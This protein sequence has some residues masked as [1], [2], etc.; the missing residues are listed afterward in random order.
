MNRRVVLDTNIIVSAMFASNSNPYRILDLA[1]SGAIEFYF[2]EPIFKEYKEVL[3]RPKFDFAVERIEVVLNSLR[4]VGN[5][6]MPI[7]SAF[8][9]TDETDRKFYDAAF[10]CGAALVTGNIKHYPNEP[11]IITP[12]NFLADSEA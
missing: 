2:S 1:L 3:F 10:C 5:V 4:N 12:A 6:V 8:A 7:P 11:F 9:M